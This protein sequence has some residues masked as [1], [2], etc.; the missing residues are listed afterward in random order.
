[1]TRTQAIRRV[2]F[3]S[4]ITATALYAGSGFGQS[5]QD[6]ASA[7]A[8]WSLQPLSPCPRPGKRKPSLLQTLREI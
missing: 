4:F 6:D 7:A 5:P 1:M 2:G 3:A 8:E